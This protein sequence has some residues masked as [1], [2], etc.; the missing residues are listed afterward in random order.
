MLDKAY[1]W[2]ATH[3]SAWATAWGK[4]AGLPNSIM[5]VA[6]KTDA[7]TP[8]AITS[9]TVSS[10]QNLVNQFYAAGLIPNEGQHLELHH[11]RVQ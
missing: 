3:P 1:I 2:A 8:V 10:E 9:V 7:T 5:D 6:A 4:A 11:E